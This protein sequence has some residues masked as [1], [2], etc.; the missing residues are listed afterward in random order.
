[1][2]P[3]ELPAGAPSRIL[4]LFGAGRAWP[5]FFPFT[6]PL[7][8]FGFAGFLAKLNIQRLLLKLSGPGHAAP[9][10]TVPRFKNVNP[11]RKLKRFFVSFF[12]YGGFR[13]GLTCSRQRKMQLFE[14]FEKNRGFPDFFEKFLKSLRGFRIF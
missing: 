13:I 11:T 9:V 7:Q 6:F 14:N 10:G 4:K 8:F 12:L 5:S 3:A 2:Q 1:M